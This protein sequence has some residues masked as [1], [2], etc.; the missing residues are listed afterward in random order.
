MRR[1]SSQFY[2]GMLDIKSIFVCLFVFLS[3]LLSLIV[4]LR[5]CEIVSVC[6][7]AHL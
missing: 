7:V 4:C 6:S 5:G 2:F 1:Q 3:A